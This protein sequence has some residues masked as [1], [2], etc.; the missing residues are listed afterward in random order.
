MHHVKDFHWRAFIKVT[1]SD[2]DGAWSC[3]RVI[4]AIGMTLFCISFFA[5]TFWG[6]KTDTPIMNILATIVVSGLATT[7]SER[8]GKQFNAA[9]P[10]KEPE[11]GDLP[12]SEPVH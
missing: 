11:G 1:L 4:T 10:T 8:F 7:A 6:F 9:A 5:N 2:V 3:K 12:Q